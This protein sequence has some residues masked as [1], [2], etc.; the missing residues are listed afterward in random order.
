[1]ECLDLLADQGAKPAVRPTT[2]S[3]PFKIG[4]LCDSQA[5]SKYVFD[6]ATWIRSQPNLSVALIIHQNVQAEWN[7]TVRG[8][9]GKLVQTISRN[10]F[11]SVFSKALFHLVTAIEGAFLKRTRHKDHTRAFD[12]SSLVSESIT[13]EPIVSQSGL[14]YRFSA[15]DVQRVKDLNCDVLIRCGR[16]NILRGDI[17]HAARHGILSFHHADNRI[18]RGGP[19]GFWEVYKRQDTTGFTIQRLT[20][21]LDGGVVFMRGHFQTKF[22]YLLNQASLLERSNRFL[23]AVIQDTASRGE[24][25]PPLPSLPYSEQLFRSPHAGQTLLYSLRL[26]ARLVPK[27]FGTLAGYRLRW[28]VAFLRSDWRNAVLW[29][30]IELQNPPWHFLADPFVISRNGKDYCFVEDFDYRTERGSI[31]VYEL[32][33]RGG[34]RIGTALAEDFHLSFPFLFEY[35]GDLFMCPES[36]EVK[37]IRIYRCVEFPLRWK[38]ETVTM[39]NVNAVDSLIFE[40]DGQWWLLTN[41]DPVGTRMGN[42]RCE[43]FAFHATSPFGEWVAHPLNP[44]VVDASCAGNGGLLVEA[45]QILR[46]SQ[47]QG[48]DFYGRQLLINEVVEL[49]PQTYRETGVCKITPTFKRGIAGTHHLHSNGSVTVFDYVRRSRITK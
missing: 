6:L 15:S 39:R 28:H 5:V 25:P 44:I 3:S 49:T 18:N 48:F 30:A 38:L 22:C 2:A 36:S 8:R 13:I 23:N 11:F 29:R 19:P 26:L 14:V 4:L 7:A 33:K 34:V 16:G 10:G 41:I 9:L 32:A 1:M 17:L 27:I 46:V 45:G 12:L 35:Q 43:L 37:E 20:E 21:E 47:A 31:A 24:L 42:D 40:K